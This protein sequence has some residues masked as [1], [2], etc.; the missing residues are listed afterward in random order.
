MPANTSKPLS[1]VFDEIYR[2]DSW[3]VGSG[4]GSDPVAASAYLVFLEQF[5]LKHSPKTVLDV[6]CG[7]GRLADAIKWDELLVE[8][9]GVDISGVAIDSVPDLGSIW[10]KGAFVAK[11]DVCHPS[12]SPLSDLAI[13]KDVF[14][15]L[16]FAECEKILGALTKC[17]H[18]LVTNDIPGESQEDCEAGGYR[19][20]DITR[21]PLSWPCVKVWEGEIA[22][23]SKATYLITNS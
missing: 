7:D 14:Q 8:Y 21:P 10:A 19:P 20:I 9:V 4:P 3:G 13:I 17:R 22:G 12:N 11:A 15:H 6:G 5:I 18:I 16:P 2:K 1:E 23:F